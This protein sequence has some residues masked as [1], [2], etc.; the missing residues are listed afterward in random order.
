MPTTK[1]KNLLYRLMLPLKAPRLERNPTLTVYGRPLVTCDEYVRLLRK[2]HV[3]GCACLLSNDR[4]QVRIICS[5]EHP[6]HTVTANSMF[7]V[8]S[9]TKMVTSLAAIKAVE[10]GKLDLVTP[11]LEFFSPQPNC[12]ELDGVTIIQLLSHTAGLNDPP[13]MESALIEGVPFPDLISGRS[14]CNVQKTF[15]YSN[16]GF[17]LIGCVLEAAY[18]SPV[19]EIIR[20]KIFEPLEMNATLEASTLNP[21]SIVPISRILPYHSQNEVVVTPLGKIPLYKPD[22]LRHYGHTAGAM[23]T[24]LDSLEKL[25]KCLMQNGKPIL[26]GS[27][28]RIMTQRHASYGKADRK[29]HY[30]LGLLIIEDPAVSSSRI[31]GHQGFAYG[32]ADGAFWE[33]D[34]GRML[35]FLNGGASEARTGRMGLCNRDLLKWGLRKEIPQWSRS[36]Q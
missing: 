35:L 33:E 3:M 31:L 18:Q 4:E 21:R 2:H 13:D 20:S 8:A 29:L 34:T 10:E 11:I 6:R 27:A 14:D 24:D 9:I 1:L 15:H 7:R 26:S 16:L 17:G 28:S 30:G 23:Y 32:C 22:P 25:M 19:S 5:S 12:P 36:M